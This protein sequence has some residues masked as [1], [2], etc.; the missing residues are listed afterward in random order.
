M[1]CMT[2]LKQIYFVVIFS[3]LFLLCGCGFGEMF[4]SHNVERT[5]YENKR[6]KCEKRIHKKTKDGIEKCYFMS[7]TLQSE[8][9]YSNGGN[10]ILTKS[11]WGN[12]KDQLV[13]LK[14]M[15]PEVFGMSMLN[16]L[17]L[18]A[19]SLIEKHEICEVSG[20]VMSE[21]LFK[22]GKIIYIKEFYCNGNKEYEELYDNGKLS[23]A[24]T[25]FQDG[26]IKYQ[27]TYKNDV[28][29][30]GKIYDES[31]NLVFNENLNQI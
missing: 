13:E 8:S 14:N 18:E 17:S 28:L 26:M 10:D 6:L 9:I 21:K 31:G 3:F 20:R 2:S 5:F 19:I 25:Y 15:H 1:F 27:D 4:N 30:N 29:V 22:L 24:S 12:S 23:T 16:M 7:G 11:Y